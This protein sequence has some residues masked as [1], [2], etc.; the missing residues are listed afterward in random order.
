MLSW[1][2][3]GL[4][5]GVLAKWLMPGKDPGGLIVTTLLGIAGALIGGYL[6]SLAGLGSVSGFNVRSLLLAVGGAVLV[7]LVYRSVTRG[8]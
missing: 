5:V 8:R 7:L 1:I 3:L 6:G 4:A 2:I